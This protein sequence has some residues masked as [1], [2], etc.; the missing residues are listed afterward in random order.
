MKIKRCLILSILCCYFF[1]PSLVI[2]DIEVKGGYL[3]AVP[4][5][6]MMSAA[7]M[8]LTNTTDRE[9]TIIGGSSPAVKAIELHQHTMVN[10]VMKMRRIPSL[11][12]QPA[13]SVM[14]EP[15]GLHIMFIGLKG[16]LTKGDN[17]SFDLKF[18]NGQSQTLTLPVKSIVNP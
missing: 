1:S 10:G 16:L 13:S 18:Q 9:I 4:P 6:Q 17:F 7:F 8:Q 3:R 15:G 14:L 12:I 11:S 5:G 2:A